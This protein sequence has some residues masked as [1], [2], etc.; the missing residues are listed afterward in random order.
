MPITTGKNPVAVVAD[1]TGHWLYVGADAVYGYVIAPDGSLTAVPGSSGT[2]GDP[3]L[4]LV[5]EASGKYLYAGNDQ[6][7]TGFTVDTTTGALTAGPSF[8][9]PS[10]KGA[11]ALTSTFNVK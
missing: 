8:P 7:I 5:F 9:F 11:W 3:A 1:P 2:I 6:G 4:Y 10:G